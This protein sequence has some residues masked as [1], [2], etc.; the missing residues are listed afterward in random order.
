M[1]IADLQGI[2]DILNM[3]GLGEPP[4]EKIMFLGFLWVVSTPFTE[5][6][7][8]QKILAIDVNLLSFQMTLYNLAQSRSMLQGLEDNVES[9]SDERQT[10]SIWLH[11]VHN[12]LKPAPI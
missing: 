12:T 6:L 8:T 1:K 11:C 2:V 5:F 10:M 9:L 3:F 7:Q 4:T